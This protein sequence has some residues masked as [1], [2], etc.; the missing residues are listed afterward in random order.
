MDTKRN[1]PLQVAFAL[2]LLA[3]LGTLALGLLLWLRYSILSTRSVPFLVPLWVFD[4]AFRPE[5]F[6]IALYGLLGL[7]G[8]CCGGALWLALQPRRN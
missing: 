1:R 6:Q 8:L 4:L 7:N 2:G 5:R 3:L